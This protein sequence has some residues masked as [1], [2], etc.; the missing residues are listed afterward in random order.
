MIISFLFL[1]AHY[2]CLWRRIVGSE[3]MQYREEVSEAEALVVR[4]EMKRIRTI[5]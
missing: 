5:F 3:C 2:S 4:T 1:K